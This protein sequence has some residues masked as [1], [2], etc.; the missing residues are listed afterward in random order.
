MARRLQAAL[1]DLLAIAPPDRRAALQKQLDLLCADSAEALSNQ[2]DVA[3]AQQPDAG[4]SNTSH[5]RSRADQ[6]AD[7]RI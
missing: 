3:R 6:Q 7:S 4:G 2:E 1:R 5:G